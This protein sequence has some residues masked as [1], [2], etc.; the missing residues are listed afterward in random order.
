MTLLIFGIGGMLLCVVIEPLEEAV[1][2]LPEPVAQALERPVH[3]QDDA[4]GDD[5]EAVVVAIVHDGI[6]D[7][8]PLVH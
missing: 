5:S 6:L 4:C 1:A 3:E 2:F 7:A 8:E